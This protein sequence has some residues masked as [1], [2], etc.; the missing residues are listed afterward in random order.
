MRDL[1]DDERDTRDNPAV[2]PFTLRAI[3]E[4][5]AR[6][7]HDQY[8]LEAIALGA[9]KFVESRMEDVHDAA[10]LALDLRRRFPDMPDES[11]ATAVKSCTAWGHKRGAFVAKDEP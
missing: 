6:T 8:L 9:E 2:W 11:V 7:Y 10:M 5:G 4:H 3:A 1:T